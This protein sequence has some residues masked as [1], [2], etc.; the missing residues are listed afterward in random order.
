MNLHELISIILMFIA[1]FYFIVLMVIA[2]RRYAKFLEVI[3]KEKPNYLD[4]VGDLWIADRME[5]GVGYQW[6]VALMPLNEKVDDQEI[7]DAIKNHKKIILI[8]WLS[9]ITIIPTLI[10]Y[11]KLS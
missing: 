10:I 8:F 11:S 5:F 2:H 9:A 3:V 7:I 1:I 4:N 6:F